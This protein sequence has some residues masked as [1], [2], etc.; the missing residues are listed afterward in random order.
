MGMFDRLTTLVKSNINDLISKAENPEKMLN[1]L[2][3]DMNEQYNE[4]SKEVSSTIADEKRLRKSFE[5]QEAQAKEWQERAELAVN[6]GNDELALKALKRKK[7][8]EELMEQYRVQ[9]EGQ[10]EAADQLKS[11]LRELKNKIEEA[12]RNRNMLIA[13]AK[14]A[15]AQKTIQKTMSGLNDN[16][17]FDAFDRM[18]EKVDFIEAEAEAQA[19]LNKAMAGDDLES[20]FAELENEDSE[21]MDELAKLKAKLNKATE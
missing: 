18:S 8:H 20:Q 7:E 9:W 4:A 13:R 2:I 1:Q 21:V 14:K 6:K 16:S 5:E 19:E 10:K 15:E 12:K 11:Q 17:A 3:I